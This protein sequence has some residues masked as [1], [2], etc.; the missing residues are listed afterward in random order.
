MKT[1]LGSF[2][3]GT[4]KGDDVLFKTFQDTSKYLAQ[5]EINMTE[6]VS[7]YYT[8]AQNDSSTREVGIAISHYCLPERNTVDDNGVPLGRCLIF[9]PNVRDV[10]LLSVIAGQKNETIRH[11]G[12]QLRLLLQVAQTMQFLH[13]RDRPIVHGHLCSENLLFSRSER[14]DILLAN[15]TCSFFEASATYEG[16]SKDGLRHHEQDSHE[17][18][19][20]PTTPPVAHEP[21]YQSLLDFVVRHARVSGKKS[22]DVIAFGHLMLEVLS[23]SPHPWRREPAPQEALPGPFPLPSFS[24]LIPV[25]LMEIITKCLDPQAELTMEEIVLKL[26]VQQQQYVLDD[27]HYKAFGV[28]EFSDL[29]ELRWDVQQTSLIPREMWKKLN[30]TRGTWLVGSGP[31]FAGDGSTS[32]ERKEDEPKERTRADKLRDLILNE[33][34]LSRWQWTRR[35]IT[36]GVQEVDMIY[37]AKPDRLFKIKEEVMISLYLK[38]STSSIFQRLW[39]KAVLDK[40]SADLSETLFDLFTKDGRVRGREDEPPKPKTSSKKGSGSKNGSESKKESEAEKESETEKESEAMKK[41]EYKWT[42]RDNLQQRNIMEVFEKYGKNTLPSIFRAV[43]VP[44]QFALWFHAA[45]NKD[46]AEAICRAKFLNISAL[47]SGWYGSGIYFTDDLEYATAYY[48]GWQGNFKYVVAAQVHV[49]RT[50]PVHV[51]PKSN[52][53]FMGKPLVTW[54]DSHV[55]TVR[56]THSSMTGLPVDSKCT[57][58]YCMELCVKE[59]TPIFPRAILQIRRTSEL[60]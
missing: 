28:S 14:P 60:N 19:Y 22:C 2:Q 24:Y 29:A 25:S 26:K 32:G 27:D 18:G 43:D 42:E 58:E 39:E 51:N 49:A 4:L 41:R 33:L 34:S 55:A 46:V 10:H 44:G 50:F 6:H 8:E 30:K 1:L 12:E 13:S 56:N 59:G 3:S 17:S 35:G 45:P 16:E 15:F 54:H 40:L 9:S 5:H 52:K 53:M 21:E 23:A 20:Y 57:S 37:D 38:E 7:A 31:I 36:F 48:G 47:D 11:R